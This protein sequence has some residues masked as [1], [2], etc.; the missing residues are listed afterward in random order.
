M[1]WVRP[2]DF[3]AGFTRGLQY[4]GGVWSSRI[5]KMPGDEIIV[6]GFG[7]HDLQKSGFDRSGD[8]RKIAGFFLK[9]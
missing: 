4:F 2:W 7:S 5:M 8:M 6:S 9:E 3:L 1:I